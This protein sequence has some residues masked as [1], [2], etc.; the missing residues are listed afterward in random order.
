MQSP[1]DLDQVIA[2]SIRNSEQSGELRQIPGWGKPLE[3]DESYAATP[4]ELRMPYKI[5]KDA[6]C[7]P[8]EVEMM[9]T[10]AVLRAELAELE[11]ES[12][13]W[14]A[15]QRQVQQLALNIS[16]QMERLR[17]GG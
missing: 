16:L 7:V 2:A 4:A 13:A 5:L 14:Q 6:G 8:A 9:K 15:K 12:P 17:S 11:A 1:R 10:L 3:L